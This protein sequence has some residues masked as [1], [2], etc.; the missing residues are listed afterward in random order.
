MKVEGEVGEDPSKILS[1]GQVKSYLTEKVYKSD[2]RKTSHVRTRSGTSVPESRLK[3]E[4]FLI[5]LQGE[6]AAA[7]QEKERNKEEHAKQVEYKK[8]AG[9]RVRQL[10]TVT[11]ERD[12]RDDAKDAKKKRRIS[13]TTA[14]HE[15]KGSIKLRTSMLEEQIAL[16][17]ETNRLLTLMLKGNTP[18]TTREERES[19]PI[20]GEVQTLF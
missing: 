3:I 14:L 12:A 11:V 20:E 17:K 2:A 1:A 19:D 4:D 5:M 9:L 15:L 6:Q 8:A 13:S 18:L 10:C 7:T 16:S